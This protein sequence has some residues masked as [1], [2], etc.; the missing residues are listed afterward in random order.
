MLNSLSHHECVEHVLDTIFAYD[1][2]KDP[3]DETFSY[4]G[5]TRQENDLI[6]QSMDALLHLTT[7]KELCK[8]IAKN[9]GLELLL[10]IYKHFDHNMNVKLILNKIVSNMTSCHTICEEFHKSGWIYLLSHWQ[11]HEDLRIQVLA[12]TAL[13]NLDRDDPYAFSYPTKVYPLYPRGKYH[14]K[15]E[16]V[17]LK[18]FN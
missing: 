2:V 1:K 14:K 5:I 7:K 11:N 9:N 15:P 13:S 4:G 3:D 16:M 10:A 8:E 18:K 17:G 12:S 6:I